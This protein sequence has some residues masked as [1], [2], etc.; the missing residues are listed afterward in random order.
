MA[1][2]GFP[3]GATVTPPSTN[4]KRPAPSKE[5]SETDVLSDAQ[6]EHQIKTSLAVIYGFSTMLDDDWDRL[7]D[8]K[9]RHGVATI[10]RATKELMQQAEHLLRD[11]KRDVAGRAR[12]VARVD[13]AELV[14]AA[15]ARWN[16]TSETTVVANDSA[17]PLFAWVD[18]FGLRHVLGHLVDNAIKYSPDRGEV[19]IRIATAGPWVSIDVADHG[20]GIP[21]DINV[22]A[23]FQ[24]AD[25][26]SE[27]ATG[28]GLGLH[29]ART[30]VEAM[31]GSLSAKRN[32]N[33]GSTFAVRVR[34]DRP[35]P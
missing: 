2:D 5:E 16:E 18:S 3:G 14:R 1:A 17:R 22:F 6:R 29:V 34:R 31:G 8:A 12:P 27:P 4:G 23:P 26:E 33:G 9:R 15:A 11:A 19:S 7:S 32:S 30:I 25:S 35:A 24:K 28:V 20:V 13:V 21:H 10:G